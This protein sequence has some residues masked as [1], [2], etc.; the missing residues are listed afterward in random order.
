ML[1]TRITALLTAGA[2]GLTLSA[3]AGADDEA[4]DPAVSAAE[5]AATAEEATGGR[6]VAGDVVELS[7]RM[8]QAQE[9]HSTVHVES[10]IA[11]EAVELAGMDGVYQNADIV[12]GATLDEMRM[13]M[14]TDAMGMTVEAVI[15]DS[16]MYMDM[17]GFSAG[18]VEYVA[19]DLDEAQE[20]AGVAQALDLLENADPAAQAEMMA[21]AV[22][23]FEYVGTEQV[24]G[25]ELDV[26]AV[27]IDAAEA[28][29]PALLGVDPSTLDEMDET[30]VDMVFRLDGDGLPV[31]FDM[32]MT[33]EGQEVVL[34]TTY[35]DWGKDVS[36]EA[37]PAD[38]VA[39][40]EEMMG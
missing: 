14:T 40:Y 15:V 10:G 35:S 9:G 26:Y 34:T 38:Q 25:T 17:S 37:P 20:E 24:G 31:S 28:F 23:S 21:D 11:G 4:V 30:P 19:I 8:A 29:D 18:E 16:T 13:R 12:L 6:P 2:V 5:A 1:R 3:C 27:T 22:E 36:I 33:V 39:D 7:E 32:T